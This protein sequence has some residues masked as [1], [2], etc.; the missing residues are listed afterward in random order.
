MEQKSVNFSAEN[1][2]YC[3]ILRRN[4]CAEPFFCGILAAESEF[5]RDVI[6][7]GEQGK[8]QAMLLGI[9]IGAVFLLALLIVI[10]AVYFVLFRNFHTLL[11]D[12]SVQLVQAMAGQGVTMVEKELEVGRKQSVLLAASLTLPQSQGQAVSFPE[13]A[14]SDR[15]VLRLLYASDSRSVASDGR[16]RD[17]RGREDI[18]SALQGKAAVY[19]PRFNADGEYVVCYSAPVLRGG[20]I[21]GAVCVEKD[22]YL[23]S[24]LIK[25]I[26]FVNS[27]E[28]YIIDAGGTDIAVSDLT[29][30]EWVNAQYNAGKLLKEQEDA[31]TRSIYQLEQKGLRG[32]TGVGTY[33]WKGSAC[34]VAYAPIPS[35]RWVL[36]AGLR[37]EEIA[38]MTQSTLLASFSKGTALQLCLA[39][40]FLLAGLI[41]FWIVSSMKKNAEIAEKLEIIANHDPLTGLLNR[42]FLETDLT[43]RWKYPVKVSGQ[44]A[45]F[46]VDIDDFKG[47][48]DRYG[49]PKGDDCLRRVA[50]VFK[51][52]FQ[53]CDGYVMRYGGEEFTAVVFLMGRQAAL[54][55]GQQICR[56]VEDEQLPNGPDRY[57]TVSIGVSYVNLTLGASLYECIK[58]ADMALYEAKKAGKNRAHLLDVEAVK[59]ARA[60]VAACGG[61]EEL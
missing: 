2:G 4:R 21:M 32:E 50:G 61:I 45:I 9:R 6:R 26:R 34:Y 54:E 47:Y 10:A 35:M 20:E 29:H 42:R 13:E 14:L 22:A 41:V 39:V 12:Y 19:G 38:A 1:P 36:L 24:R 15:D 16:Q 17:V 48:N 59:E 51:H 49:H 5:L 31:T 43:A 7:V 28:S 53:A 56:L 58:I 60:Q 57:V 33:E 37:E 11:T 18:R 55:K 40:V 25:D 27:G 52:A 23:F 44:A 30:I 3:V 46:M 8:K